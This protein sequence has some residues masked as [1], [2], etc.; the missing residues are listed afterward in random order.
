MVTTKILS[1]TDVPGDL[2]DQLGKWLAREGI[3]ASELNYCLE[4]ARRPFSPNDNGLQICKAVE[5]SD[6]RLKSS[7][8]VAGLNLKSADSIGR[9]MSYDPDF[10][11]LVTT[12][13]ALLTHHDTAYAT[14]AICAMVPD[15]TGV[16]V[17]FQRNRLFPIVKK[18]VEDIALHVVNCGN[19]LKYPEGLRGVCRH[20]VDSLI[21]AAAIMGVCQAEGNVVIYSNKFLADIYMWLLAHVEGKVSLLVANEVVHEMQLGNSQK[22]VLMKVEEACL[23]DESD[24]H[25]ELVRV[26]VIA[27]TKAGVKTLLRRSYVGHPQSTPDA[28]IRQSFYDLGGHGRDRYGELKRQDLLEIKIL[29]QSIVKWIMDRPLCAGS[30]TQIEYLAQYEQDDEAAL[31]T[32][33][34]TVGRLMKRLPSICNIDYGQ[35]PMSTDF[36]PPDNEESEGIRS[37]SDYEI[38]ACFP[39]SADILDFIRQRCQCPGCRDGKARDVYN[40]PL[41]LGS[42]IRDR[43]WLIIAHAVADGF[44]APDASNFGDFA[45]IREGVSTLMCHMVYNELVKWD[46]WFSLAA[47]TFLGCPFAGPEVGS[48]HDQSGLAVVQLGSALVVAPWID[49]H[50]DFE[51]QGSFGF[52]M[53]E[54]QIRGMETNFGV[55]KIEKENTLS[56]VE[57]DLSDPAALNDEHYDADNVGL[58]A[59]SAITGAAGSPYRLILSVTAGDYTRLVNPSIAFMALMHST[60]PTCDHDQSDEQNALSSTSRTWPAEK[61]VGLWE[62]SNWAYDP[63]YRDGK[64]KIQHI[65]HHWAYST[66][67]LDTAAVRNVLLALSPMGCVIK[68]RHCCFACAEALAD[69][70]PRQSTA[71]RIL[72]VATD[73]RTL[74]ARRRRE[75]Q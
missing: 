3:H 52:V 15:E 34:L 11:Y 9:W 21:F 48:E 63:G 10:R 44:G 61:A 69:E 7:S 70:W 71:K 72:C 42:W 12:V 38:L 57:I 65:L 4:Q 66:E 36:V 46:T 47:R 55:A 45:V 25:R 31:L 35:E 59:Q 58:V 68:S 17:H 37:I 49:L 60:E 50:Q 32:S 39:Q 2:T 22:T 73:W 43:L 41:C 16:A 67:L 19:T 62:S 13:A 40:D 56:G 29:G 33:S 54:G 24:H 74:A 53:A 1:K 8:Q 23:R 5:A 30:G 64:N 75:D 28:S 20:V 26:A 6:V 51:V 14:D 27:V 18:I